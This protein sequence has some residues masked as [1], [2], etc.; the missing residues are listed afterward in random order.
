MINRV[1]STILGGLSP[2]E[3]FYGKPPCFSHMKVVGCHCFAI[4]L[5]KQDKF[6]PRAIKSVMM[7]YAAYQKGYLLYDLENRCFFISKDVKFFEHIFPFKLFPPERHSPTAFPQFIDAADCPLVISTH[8]VVSATP[9]GSMTESL[10]PP[11]LDQSVELTSSQQDHC[12]GDLGEPV[13]P[14]SAPL[15]SSVQESACRRSTR[16]SKPP[17]WL[18]DFI[19]PDKRK[20]T[21]NTCLYP[22]SEVMGYDS[23]SSSYQSITILKLSE[24]SV[25]LLS[26]CG[27]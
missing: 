17:I 26:G 24:F 14:S 25:S 7:G 18:K 12:L 16:E 1:P 5:P 19:R 11:V 6:A 2:F 10:Q 23:L 3:V 13:I 9:L 27:T 22:L 15:A 21:A 4:H 8:E 20:D